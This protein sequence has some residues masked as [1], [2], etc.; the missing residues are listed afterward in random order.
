LADRLLVAISRP[1][2]QAAATGRVRMAQ[3]T[4]EQLLDIIDRRDQRIAQ[5]ESQVEQLTAQVRQLTAQ[6]QDALRACKRQAAPFS[7]GP[8][9]D[10]PKRPGRKAGPDYGTKA[11]RPIPPAEP[12]EIIDVPLPG[13]CPNCGG[14]TVEDHTDQQF[15]TE[16][17][18]KPL[19]RRFDIHIGHCRCCGKR[20]QPRHPLQTSDALGAA[21]SQLG[22]DA[23]A[24]IAHLNKHAGMPH[25]KIAQ[26]FDAFFGI[27]LSRGGACNSMLR[28][29]ERAMPIYQSI[30]R[31]LGK[32]P[33]IVP[34]ETGW[35]RGGHKAWMHDFVTESLTCYVIDTARGGVAERI[36]GFRYAGVLIHDGFG[37]YDRFAFARHQT[38]LNHLLTRCK[39]LLL[40]A[41]AGAVRFPRQVQALLAHALAV[42]DRRDAGQLSPHGLACCVGR[43][44]ARLGR[45]LGGRLSNDDNHRLADHLYR[46]Q[47]H[48]F[49]FLQVP[50]IDATN[51]RAERAIRP[52]VLARKIS[53]ASRTE[54][55]AEAHAALCSVIATARQQGRDVCQMLADLLC[56]RHPRLAYLPAG[57]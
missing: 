7:K 46:Q 44:K 18:R 11:H 42:R 20:I 25:G 47:H 51:H 53:G 4:Y 34:D 15:Q 36:I 35:R 52:A 33:W 3:P 37:S 27:R 2:E 40:T 56:G 30:V 13:R 14:A 24:A 5:L 45:L 54:R 50:G 23:H 28:S 41:R 21:A 8:P 12:D 1:V 22:P 9:K 19:V 55:G 49:T 48:L 32:F 17:P 16:I 38:C 39:N 26:F 31:S 6:L 29:A 43:L 10:R 57:P